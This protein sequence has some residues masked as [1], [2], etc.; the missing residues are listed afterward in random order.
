MLQAP[1]RWPNPG[2]PPYHARALARPTH[3]ERHVASGATT[4]T[5][6]GGLADRYAAAL[7]SLAEDQHALDQVVSEMET[8]GR[9]IEASPPPAPARQRRAARTTV[10]CNT[11]P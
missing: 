5:S 1:R 3:R 8:L 7:Y 4:I 2:R 10:G 11:P 6:G 9:T